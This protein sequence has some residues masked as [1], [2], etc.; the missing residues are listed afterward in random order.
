[1]NVRGTKVDRAQDSAQREG[2][3]KDLVRDR[4]SVS[5]TELVQRGLKCTIDRALP[6]VN[7]ELTHSFSTLFSVGGKPLSRLIL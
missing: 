3:P 5:G 6:G 2:E 1:M 7:D 4:T